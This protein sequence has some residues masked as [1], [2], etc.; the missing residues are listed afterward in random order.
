MPGKR[1]IP[2]PQQAEETPGQRPIPSPRR[3]GLP[4]GEGLCSR[5]RKRQA[6]GLSHHHT[7][8]GFRSR[9][10]KHQASGLSRLPAGQGL[11]A[12]GGL[13]SRLRKRQA[14]GL[15]HHH[16]GVGLRAPQPRK[17]PPGHLLTRTVQWSTSLVC[18]WWGPLRHKPT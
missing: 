11:P 12:C 15:S 7:G 2:P 16:A 5:L 13:C 1:P 8:K 4:A 17:R 6:N 9:L 3:E 10:R 18:F 14:N